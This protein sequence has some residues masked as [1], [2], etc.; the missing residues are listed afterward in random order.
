MGS[1]IKFI[2]LFAGLGGFHVALSDLDAECVFASEVD[3]NLQNLYHRNFG[4]K[5]AG[6]IRAVENIDIPFHDVLC[7]GF[8]C[9]PFSKA[10]FQEGV[11]DVNRGSL[12]DEIVRVLEFHRPAFF[13]LEN[14]PNLKY[15]NNGQTWASI[16]HILEKTLKYNIDHALLSPHE[17]GIPQIRERF[18]VV[19]SKNSLIHF[20]WPI[21]Y[22]DEELSLNRVL[23]KYPK[24]AISLPNREKDCLELWQEFLNRIP[25]KA[26]LPSFPI[27]SM[28]FGATYP[29]EEKTPHDCSH[30]ELNN[31]L[32]QFGL[33]LFGMTKNAQL[34][35][36]PKYAR[37]EVSTFP[38]W[39]QR[40]IEQ[41]RE[42]YLQ[43]KREIDPLLPEIMKLP[44]SWQK[45]EWNCQGEERNL[46]NF[47]LQFRASGIRV[48]RPNYSPSLIASTS[49]QIPII[50]WENR[51]MTAHEAA[52]L[53]SIEELELPKSETAAFR[54]LGNAVN[55]KI[56]SLIAKR[57][58]RA[59]EKEFLRRYGHESTTPTPELLNL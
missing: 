3:K 39:K 30:K 4:L 29:F 32:G 7:A 57:L 51:Y 25:N 47:I 42:F 14:V 44:S 12:F 23:D 46:K 50:G 1:S 49:T 54:A 11:R 8:P 38:K 59:P 35:R 13:I 53:Q 17:F 19:G 56:V 5:P 18:F 55:A 21:R 10:G 15:H 41:N 9:Q 26:K 31:H 33:S 16:R 43:H 24:D 22:K 48:K 6:D 37:Q 52:R 45:F 36:I 58:I 40:F 20:E 2:D 27:W 28:E 34:E